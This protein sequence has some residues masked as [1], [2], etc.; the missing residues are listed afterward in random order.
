AFSANFGYRPLDKSIPLLAL[1]AVVSHALVLTFFL[2]RHGQPTSQSS[3]S[4]QFFTDWLAIRTNQSPFRSQ[5]AAI[6]WRQVRETAPLALLAIGGVFA[7]VAFAYFAD[8]PRRWQL[9]DWGNMLG[10]LTLTVG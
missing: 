7:F 5:A 6:V 4:R 8:D 10:A 9:R 3:A 1:L 2:K